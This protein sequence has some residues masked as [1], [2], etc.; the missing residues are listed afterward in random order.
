MLFLDL[1]GCSHEARAE[2]TDG[3]QSRSLLFFLLLLDLELGHGCL[4]ILS[5]HHG[6]LLSLLN[7]PLLLLKR[8]LLLLLSLFQILLR[9]IAHLPL[10]LELFFLL[11]DFV[12]VVVSLLLQTNDLVILLFKQSLLLLVL[13]FCVHQFGLHVLSV[14]RM[15]HLLLLHRR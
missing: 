15:V 2:A 1:F 6:L 5:D 7:L 10:K 9:N 3:H 14:V 13:V 12:V 8:L 4:E 11:D